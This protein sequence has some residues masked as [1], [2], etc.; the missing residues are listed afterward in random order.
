MDGGVGRALGITEERCTE[1]VAANWM[2][3]VALVPALSQVPMP[4]SLER[5]LKRVPRPQSNQVLR[6]LAELAAESGHNDRDAAFVLAWVLHAGADALIAR[7][8]DVSEEIDQHVAAFL[9]IEIRT[10]PWRR[11]RRVA[12]SILLR[13]RQKVLVEGGNPAQVRNHSRVLAITRPVS[14]ERMCCLPSPLDESP[15]DDLE[16]F[17]GRAYS[18]RVITNLERRILLDLVDAAKVR[19]VR[20]RANS[21]LFGDACCDLVGQRWGMSGRKVRRVAKAAIEVLTAWTSAAA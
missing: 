3:W 2:R 20:L 12:S 10:Y 1:L 14:P 19:P 6:G 15:R 17:L 5:W 4:C 7:L 21:T 11:Q 9:W 8:W 18:R 13:V 16:D